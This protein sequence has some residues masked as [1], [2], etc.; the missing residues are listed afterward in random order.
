MSG[1]GGGVVSK[2][3]FSNSRCKGFDSIILDN[4]NG[5]HH[6]LSSRRPLDSRKKSKSHVFGG[7][8]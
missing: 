5:N 6:D 7:P 8:P 2:M 3:I 4:A 1:Q